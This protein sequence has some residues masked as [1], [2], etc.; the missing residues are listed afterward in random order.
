VGYCDRPRRPSLGNDGENRNSPVHQPDCW[1]LNV[2]L[3]AATALAVSDNCL[4]PLIRLKHRAW[5]YGVMQVSSDSLLEIIE[6]I[7][8]DLPLSERRLLVGQGLLEILHAQTFVS[9]VQG[10]DGPFYDPVDINLGADS[11]KAYDDHF[12]YVDAITPQLFGKP[13]ATRI[14]PALNA[15][16]EF[17]Q[18]FLHRRHMHHGM[19]FF[20]RTPAAG[21]VDLRVWRERSAGAFTDTEVRLLNSVG[22]LIERLWSRPSAIDGVHLT[23]REAQVAEQVTAGLSDKQICTKLDFSLPTLRTHLRHIYDKVGVHNRAGLA[24]YYAQHEHHH[25]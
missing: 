15:N 23:P 25:H 7:Q 17:I 19:N 2:W 16:D 20:A 1:A 5:Y 14:S 24:G 11:L 22:S 6:I 4:W 18:D 8:S 3:E 13:G 12:R 9:Y 21:R 10:R